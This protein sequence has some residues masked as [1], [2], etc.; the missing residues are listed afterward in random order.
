MYFINTIYSCILNNFEIVE[1]N[2]KMCN[3]NAYFIIIHKIITILLLHIL[4]AIVY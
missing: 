4:G 1:S 2:L 3:Y